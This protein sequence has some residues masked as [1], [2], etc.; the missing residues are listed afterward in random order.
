MDGP[1]SPSSKSPERSQDP[2]PSTYINDDEQDS[3]HGESAAVVSFAAKQPRL[4]DSQYPPSP[5]DPDSSSDLQQ[6]DHV[7][8]ARG[9]LLTFL[10][11]S[12]YH[13][14]GQQVAVLRSLATYLSAQIKPA[15]KF[16]SDK[17]RKR[18]KRS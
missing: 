17:G 18:T 15:D 7:C 8:V 5:G 14:V 4:S 6:D 13:S 16:R 10:V 3:G 12:N 2:F 9:D 1:S 11:A